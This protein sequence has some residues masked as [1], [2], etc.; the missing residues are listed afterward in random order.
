MA[1][2]AGGGRKAK[3]PGLSVTASTAAAGTQPRAAAMAAGSS[4]PFAGGARSSAAGGA[5]CSRF[6][7]SRRTSKCLAAVLVVAV[8]AAAGI[9]VGITLSRRAGRGAEEE[10]PPVDGFLVVRN[11]KVGG[12]V[13]LC[14]C[15]SVFGGGGAWWRY[16]VA[17][18][19]SACCFG[20]ITHRLLSREACVQCWLHYNVAIGGRCARCA[21]GC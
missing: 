11:M 2:P 3:K 14:V 8:I 1:S 17:A 4:N 18:D 12:R 6:L 10:L 20:G 7:P 19:P 21:A 15:K 13:L 16:G 9:G 5:G